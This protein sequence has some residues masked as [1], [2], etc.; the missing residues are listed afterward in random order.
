MEQPLAARLKARALRNFT[1]QLELAGQGV[2]DSATYIPPRKVFIQVDMLALFLL[3]AL[4]V[5][6]PAPSTPAEAGG[7]LA[8]TVC[9]L[10]PITAA[11]RGP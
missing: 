6:W 8:L 2:A 4:L 1:A 10:L 7:K 5:F 11:F 3:T 9:V